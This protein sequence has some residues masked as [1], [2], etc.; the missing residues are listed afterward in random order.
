[1]STKPEEG[2][3]DTERTLYSGGMRHAFLATFMLASAT[4]VQ[5]AGAQSTPP[6]TAKTDKV[7]PNKPVTMNGCI[8]RDSSTAKDFTFTDSANGF[9]YHLSG[10]DVSKF[11][12][13]PL[14]IVGVVDT[15]KLK[16]KTGLYPS[17]NV[18]AQAGA[19]DPGKAHV[20]A[21]GGGTTG[22][23]SG[24]IP[25]FKVAQVAAIQGECRK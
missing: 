14:Q 22:S 1:M 13:Q 24:D 11:A 15:R 4:A 17:P 16:V 21:L 19:M 2:L 6:S 12:G 5:I 10:Q 25:T 3:G 20:A 7:D 9:K 18:A 23:G 8:V